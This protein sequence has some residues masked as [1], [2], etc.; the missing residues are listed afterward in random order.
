MKIIN[1]IYVTLEPCLKKPPPDLNPSLALSN[2]DCILIP[3]HPVLRLL[4]TLLARLCLPDLPEL[5][6]LITGTCSYSCP[7]R[8]EGTTQHSTIVGGYIVYLLQ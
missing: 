8:A 5:E 6:V 2:P 7:I 4:I 1:K 3:T